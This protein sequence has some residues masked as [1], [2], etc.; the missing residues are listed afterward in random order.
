[1]KKLA[2]IFTTLLLGLSS[3][4]LPAKVTPDKG[5]PTASAEKSAEHE[6]K[7]TLW[8]ITDDNNTVYL[9]GSIHILPESAHPLP[10]SMQEAYEASEQLIVEVSQGDMG[11]G[12]ATMLLNKGQYQDGSTLAQNISAETYRA[13]GEQLKQMNL[14]PKMLD[15]YK[16]WFAG[17]MLAM[18]TME[19][20]GYSQESGVEVH[21]ETQ[22]REDGKSVESLETPEEQIEMLSSISD[23]MG[24]EMLM[25]MID[26]SDTLLKKLDEMVGYWRAGQT[27]KL[28]DLLNAEM[29]NYPELRDRLLVERNRNWIPVLEETIAGDQNTL[30]IVGAGHLIGE[31]SVVDLLRDKGHEVTRL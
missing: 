29:E 26:E 20:Q 7:T 19:K 24:E 17:L 31:E 30:V 14:S 25:Q 4:P 6:G 1:M 16:P 8:K 5:N 12:V 27:Q 2:I 10:K 9:L 11:A 18:I 28:A 3:L 21:F 23:D 22:A 13:V 15:P